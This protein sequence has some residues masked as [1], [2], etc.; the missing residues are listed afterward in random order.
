[1][2]D[3]LTPYITRNP[4]DM[5]TAEDWNEV[6]IKI[7]EDIGDQVQT[8]IGGIQNVPHAGDAD[9][10]E[11]STAQ[12]LK[13][14]IIQAVLNQ[15]PEKTG[16]LR[17]FKKLEVSE[18]TIVEHNLNAFP[19]VDLYQLDYFQ[20]VASED[21]YEYVTWVN[22]YLYH[23]SEKRIRF[24]EEDEPTSALQSIVIE[25]ADGRP[26]RI[27]FQDM[28]DLY[29]V[30]YTEDTSLGDLETDFW[31]TFFAAPNDGFDDDQY[32]HSPWFDRCCREEETVRSLKRKRNWDDIWFQ[33]RPRKTI[34]YP[35]DPATGAPNAPVI[36]DD[37][38]NPEESM[39]APTQVAV[40]HFDL[41]TL[42][43]RLLRGPVYP[44]DLLDGL[45]EH[46]DISQE[47]KVMLLL[48]V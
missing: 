1:M 32:T 18:E 39:P 22:F 25:P 10:L 8:A 24:K 44:T 17:L 46:R 13:E 40:V 43:L 16:Y 48:K 35:Y 31:D 37:R 41:N 6:Q 9:T 27:S 5:V 12:A 7:K 47:L 3:N 45:E 23:S 38:E 19:L 42:G 36:G 2:A 20:V 26:Y 11:G 29:N 21:G 28:L 4:G 33:M 14:E 30:E 15:I 34:N